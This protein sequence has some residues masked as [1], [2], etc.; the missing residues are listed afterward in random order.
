VWFGFH[1][2]LS[3]LFYVIIPY[4]YKRART[5][6][7]KQSVEHSTMMFSALPADL[8]NVSPLCLLKTFTLKTAT[9]MFTNM[10]QQLQHKKLLISQNGSYISECSS[11]PRT[12]G[13]L[14]AKYK[15][16]Y[17]MNKTKFKILFSCKWTWSGIFLK[18]FFNVT[19]IQSFITSSW[20][21]TNHGNTLNFK[22][23]SFSYQSQPIFG[24]VTNCE[25][26]KEG[27]KKQANHLGTL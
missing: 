21:S 6:N 7:M 24:F 17:Q 15:H 25:T 19:V 22:L 2:L 8:H 26:S 20:H 9:A 12:V 23:W 4:I 14:L 11:F 16:K 3:F 1:Y 27:N 5:P 10:F 13:L 18:K